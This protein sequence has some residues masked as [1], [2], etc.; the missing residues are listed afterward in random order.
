MRVAWV[1]PY[2]PEPATSG[3]AIRQQRLARALAKRGEVHLFARGDPWEQLRLG[4]R[5]LALFASRWLGRD[6]VPHPSTTDSRVVRRGSPRSLYGAIAREHERRRFDGVVVAH[7]WG[8]L[9]AGAMGLPWLLD[10][11]N[12]ESRFFAGLYESKGPLGTTQRREIDALRAWER[13]AW[14]EATAVSCVSATDAEVIAEVRRGS[15]MAASHSVLPPHVVENGVDLDRIA[16]T[17]PSERR[18][19]VLFVGA[20]HHGPNLEAA[21]RL[22]ARIMPLVWHRRPSLELTIVGGPI[23]RELEELRGRAP[24]ARITLAGRV[25]DVAPYLARHRV[26]ASPIEHGAG[27]SLKVIEA[28]AAG[29]PLVSTELGARGF[30]LVAG[31][32]YVA[33]ASDEAFADA[34][35]M[36]TDDDVTARRVAEAGRAKAVDYGWDALGNRFADLVAAVCGVT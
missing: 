31:A 9:G 26:Y 36:L 7:C 30:E 33:A 11:H 12:L 19:G 21:R 23:P 20:M 29:I 13:R 32:Q 2:L 1:S 4:S 35:V 25:A 17:P 24:A 34:I 16:Y 6:Y 15:A 5:E 10:E 22:A 27:S 14:A 3:G 18:G 8:A 28:L